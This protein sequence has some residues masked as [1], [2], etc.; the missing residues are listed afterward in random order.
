MLYIHFPAATYVYC[1]HG[2]D[3]LERKYQSRT[4]HVLTYPSLERHSDWLK[5]DQTRQA[6]TDGELLRRHVGVHVDG[7]ARGQTG[8]TKTNHM[9]MHTRQ[10]AKACCHILLDP[11]PQCL[12]SSMHTAQDRP[13]MATDLRGHSPR[14]VRN[15]PVKTSPPPNASA[16]QGCHQER[17]H[18]GGTALLYDGGENSWMGEEAAN[19]EPQ[20][21]TRPKPSN[22]QTGTKTPVTDRPEP[23]RTG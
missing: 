23:D 1:S 10:K 2:L 14:S 4:H 8:T 15:P 12:R 13:R 16:A 17:C 7:S 18:S 20:Q 9:E 19:T 21:T 22:R 5:G 6:G 11:N 3:D